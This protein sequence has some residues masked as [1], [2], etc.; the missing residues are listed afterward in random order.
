MADWSVEACRAHSA[1]VVL[2]VPAGRTGD[3]G[4]HGADTVV[5]GG[6]TRADSVRRGLASVPAEAEVIIVHDA[7]RPL[8]SPALFRAVIRAVT[9]SEDERAGTD[10]TGATT[11]VGAG[12]AIP[13]VPVHDTIKE[14]HPTDPAG[15]RRVRATLDR[16]ALVAVQ[17]PQAFRA[18][19]LRR[20]HH[21]ES[22]ATDDAAL[23]EALGAVVVVVPG[24]PRNLK[25]TTPA[26]LHEAERLLSE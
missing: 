14:V 22:D 24:D 6:A 5:D 2:V 13:G 11:T 20:A 17:T 18:D 3:G 8:A 23:V 19:L 21:A 9:G 1:G 10:R 26:D 7:A 16:S 15:T 4:L 12:G 25:I